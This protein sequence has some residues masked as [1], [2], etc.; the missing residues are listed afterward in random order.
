MT[1]QIQKT[2]LSETRRRRKLLSLYL[3]GATPWMDTASLRDKLLT[4]GEATLSDADLLAIVI[5]SDCAAKDIIDWKGSRYLIEADCVELGNISGVGVTKACKIKAA[6]ELVK[7]LLFFQGS[8]EAKEVSNPSAAAM[9][10]QAEIG[11]LEQEAVVV[12]SLNTKNKVTAIT[13]ASLGGLNEAPVCPREIF[14]TPLRRSAAGIILGHNHPSGDV[15]P[16]HQDIEATERLAK[17]GELLGIPL[18]DHLVV[19]KGLYYSMLENG[20]MTK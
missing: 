4:Y 20:K 12:L 15:T 10:L 3:K 2:R 8:Q 1:A 11:Y 16:S 5:S 14:K 17:C 18:Q 9:I 6:I 7:R 13:H 19:S